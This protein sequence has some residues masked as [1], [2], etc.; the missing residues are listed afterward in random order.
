[1]R[2]KF[3]GHMNNICSLFKQIENKIEVFSWKIGMSVFLSY[4][5]KTIRLVTKFN[6]LNMSNCFNITILNVSY[7]VWT[8]S[9]S[10]RKHA[11]TLLIFSYSICFLRILLFLLIQNLQISFIFEQPG[12]FGVNLVNKVSRCRRSSILII[13]L[14][15]K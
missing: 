9:K 1:M 10:S 15:K 8:P 13:G 12:K 6:N 11:F 14:K 2:Q 5:D 3:S 4:N 7:L